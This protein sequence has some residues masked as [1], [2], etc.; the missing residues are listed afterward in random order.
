MKEKKAPK[1]AKTAQKPQVPSGK[2]AKAVVGDA[3]APLTEAQNVKKS[4]GVK[5]AP[6]TFLKPAVPVAAPSAGRILA[7]ESSLHADN[8]CFNSM[9]SKALE[10]R[11]HGGLAKQAMYQSIL[12]AGEEHRAAINSTFLVS[13]QPLWLILSTYSVHTQTFPLLMRDG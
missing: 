4:A 9:Q 7:L 1:E 13:Y 12:A 8:K 11:K 3:A 10:D 5:H 2:G 6:E